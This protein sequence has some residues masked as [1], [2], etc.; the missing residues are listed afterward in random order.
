MNR[1]VFASTKN[2]QWETPA[3]LVDA[4]AVS[5]EWDLDVCA[6]RPN[7]CPNFISEAENSLSKQ[8]EGLCWMNPPY[9]RV[10]GLW[11][12][13]ARKEKA[14]VVCLVPARTDTRWWQ[15][16]I[17]YASLVVFVKGRLKFGSV[18][19]WHGLGQKPSPAPFPSAFVVFGD[20][21]TTQQKN[22]L[23]S[24]GHYHDKNSHRQTQRAHK[25][26]LETG[27]DNRTQRRREPLPG[28]HFLP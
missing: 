1:D 5:F 4:L 3:S 15:D 10:I 28:W 9:G 23:K 24:Y 13:K 7:V 18:E 11:V 21:L 26:A 25:G 27:W 17:R 20:I 2:Q 22:L 6:S 8:W 19:Y 14:T 16:N 12:E